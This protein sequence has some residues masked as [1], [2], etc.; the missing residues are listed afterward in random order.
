MTFYTP[1]IV[2]LF[3]DLDAEPP[4]YQDLVGEAM[5]KI[6]ENFAAIDGA[7][8]TVLNG[9]DPQN[10]V[11]SKSLSAAPTSGLTVG[12]RYIVKATPA[13]G[14]PWYGHTD[15]IAEL[16]ATSPAYAWEFVTPNKGFNLMVE[17]ENV[18]YVYTGTAW[19]SRPSVEQHNQLGGL[20]GGSETERYH[21]SAAVSTGLAAGYLPSAGEKA[22]LAGTTGAPGDANR[23]V[24]TTDPRLTNVVVQTQTITAGEALTQYQMLYC[25]AQDG[26]K[27][28]R[29]T[30][31]GAPEALEVVAICH[32]AG[33]AQGATGLAIINPTLITN[34]S[35]A[36]T[37][38]LP[39]WLGINGAIT[40]IKPTANAVCLGYAMSPTSLFF[41]PGRPADEII[42][43]VNGDLLEI[44]TI[45]VSFT[46]ELTPSVATTTQ[47]GAYIKGIDTALADI[48]ARLDAHAI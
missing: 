33:I 22:G 1:L 19:A 30:T 12:A 11:V 5:A 48:I 18:E 41:N 23:F 13:S 17:N 46:P 36:M 45:P 40:E 14:D 44:N 27:Y 31:D 32:E 24:T 6:N 21:V 3:T 20:Q 9:L 2:N 38:G 4:I 39:Q 25:N 43:E 16:T 34:E 35:W 7:I 29:A 28:Y 15:H 8:N 37:Q 42:V 26:G 47:L 10:S